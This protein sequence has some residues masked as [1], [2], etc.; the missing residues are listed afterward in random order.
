TLDDIERL[1]NDEAYLRSLGTCRL[2]DPTTAGDFLRRF[3][4]EDIDALMEA[5]NTA[6]MRVWSKMP[7]SCFD[8]AVIEINGTISGTSGACKEGMDMSYKGIWGYAPLLVTLANTGGVLYSRNRPGNRPS[9]DGA[10][11][12]LDPAVELVRE[13]GFRS[14]LLRGDSHFALTDDFDHWSDQGVRFV[15]GLAHNKKLDALAEAMDDG[16]WCDLRRDAPPRSGRPRA[17]KTRVKLQVI[18]ERKY[19]HIT[20]EDEVYTE[21]S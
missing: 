19:K 7:K 17:K 13:A 9:H 21:I 11:G 2:P 1:R 12:Y 8:R 20:L 4:L 15:F 3:R 18:K 6:R 5:I 16:E 14:V 10:F